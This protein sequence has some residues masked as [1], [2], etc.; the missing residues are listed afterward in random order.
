MVPGLG[1]GGRQSTGKSIMET[2]ITRGG[3]WEAKMTAR[4]SSWRK[5]VLPGRKNWMC[6]YIAESSQQK[7]T[8]KSKLSPIPRNV[9]LYTS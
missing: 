8:R 7:G 1:E 6:K 9:L 3:G 4:A 5:E 2:C